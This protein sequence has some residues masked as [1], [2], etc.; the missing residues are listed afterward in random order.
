MICSADSLA[1]T[2]A[3]AG[4][5]DWRKKRSLRG[6]SVSRAWSALSVPAGKG[7]EQ[8]RGAS[9]KW[10]A[11]RNLIQWCHDQARDIRSPYVLFLRSPRK[12][13]HPLKGNHFSDISIEGIRGEG[14][15][16][17]SC[18]EGIDAFS[19]CMQILRFLFDAN[20]SM[21]G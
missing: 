17:L 16:K 2:K 4:S 18:D 3:S 12:G 6:A 19:N 15:K 9:M 13:D 5:R 14:C 11:T 20:L 8:R 1:R 21:L 10:Q 7:R